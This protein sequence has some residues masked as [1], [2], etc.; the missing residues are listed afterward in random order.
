MLRH[1][2]LFYLVL[3]SFGGINAQAKV[4][5]AIDTYALN[6]PVEAC[7]SPESLAYYLK[8]TGKFSEQEKARAIYTWVTHNIRYNHSIIEQNLLGTRENTLMQQAV[9]VEIFILLQILWRSILLTFQPEF[10]SSDLKQKTIR[11]QEKLY[12]INRNMQ[13]ESFCL[14]L[15]PIVL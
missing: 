13:I 11:L 3:A 12:L 2:T 8:G 14:L 1:I 4:Y 10:I 9:F 5:A 7:K 15:L 6:A